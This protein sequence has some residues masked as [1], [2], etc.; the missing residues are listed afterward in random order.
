M[1]SKQKSILIFLCLFSFVIPV[2]SSNYDAGKV[3]PDGGEGRSW[4]DALVT[5]A[6][7]GAMLAMCKGAFDAFRSKD[8]VNKMYYAGAGLAGI[9]IASRAQKMN[10]EF[11]AAL[12]RLTKSPI[13]FFQKKSER[14]LCG[15]ESLSWNVVVSWHN[16]VFDSLTPLT[17]QSSVMDLTKDRRI[18]V[19]DQGGVDVGIDPVWLQT[20]THVYQEFAFMKKVFEQHLRYYQDQ[21]AKEQKRLIALV[22]SPLQDVAKSCVRLSIKRHE[23]T[24]FYIN[25]IMTYCDQLCVYINSVSTKESLDKELM[26]R[27]MEDLCSACKHVATLVDDTTAASPH[28]TPGQLTFTRAQTASIGGYNSYT[29]NSEYGNVHC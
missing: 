17:K 21:E 20:Q 28:G 8:S 13:I 3:M 26:K 5:G 6:G 24:A 10:P 22:A 18:K 23:E 19:L 9:Y 15:G 1:Q 25:K 2:Y 12:W 11:F 27:Y 4:L 29:A 16:R 7:D 14:F